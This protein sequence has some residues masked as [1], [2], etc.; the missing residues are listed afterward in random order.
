MFSLFFFYVNNRYLFENELPYFAVKKSIN[1]DLKVGIIGDS[2]A[3]GRKIDT[4]LA[5]EL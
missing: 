3:T 5:N 4:L 2:W 1:E